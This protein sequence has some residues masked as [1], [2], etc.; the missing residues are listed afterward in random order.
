VRAR[1]VIAVFLGLVIIAT[2]GNLWATYLLNEH[3]TRQQQQTS[4]QV[5]AK[6]CASFGKLAALK[7]PGGAAASKPAGLYEQRQHD[8]LAGLG[9]DIGCKE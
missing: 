9:V 1:V 7:P 4:Q 8:I 2:V 5:D 3:F 6:L